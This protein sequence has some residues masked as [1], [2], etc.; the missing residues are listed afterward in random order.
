MNFSSIVFGRFVTRFTGLNT[1]YLFLKLLRKKISYENLR[2]PVIKKD[3]DYDEKGLQQDM[4]NALVGVLV[5]VVVV[6][7]LFFIG[8]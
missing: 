3:G 1:R 5:I 2:P 8:A 6:T 7:I 4:Y